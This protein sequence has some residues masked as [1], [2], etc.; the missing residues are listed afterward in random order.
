MVYGARG[1]GDR[2]LG[3]LLGR[4]HRGEK[5]HPRRLGALPLGK[6]TSSPTMNLSAQAL[7]LRFNHEEF[8]DG[9]CVHPKT[10]VFAVF[11]GSGGLL[12]GRVAFRPARS[13][14]SGPSRGASAGFR[15]LRGRA[16]LWQECR[17]GPAD[18]YRRQAAGIVAPLPRQTPVGHARPGQAQLREGA[19]HELRPKVGLLRVAHPRGG[20]PQGL[21]EEAEGVLQVEPAHVRPPD[22]IEIGLSETGP[23]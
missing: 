16:Q 14:A 2:L 12:D 17:N 6:P 19:D 11:A 15:R 18:P 20:P 3:G 7:S 13:A 8:W 22:G 5:A 23:P 21:L 1:S 10:P 9:L 4:G